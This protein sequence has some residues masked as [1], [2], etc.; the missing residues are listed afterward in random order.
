MRYIEEMYTWI[1]GS[2][3]KRV[4]GKVSTCKWPSGYRMRQH[5]TLVWSEEEAPKK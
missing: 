4:V 2:M 3:A 5:V 1:V